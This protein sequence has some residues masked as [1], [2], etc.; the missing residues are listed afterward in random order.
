MANFKL[1]SEIYGDVCR[2]MGDS[3]QSRL[4]EAKAII[5]MVYLQEIMNCDPLYPCLWFLAYLD[6]SVLTKDS[7]TITGITSATPPVVSAAAHGFAN[8][9]IVQIAGVVGMTEV[10]NRI[11]VVADRAAG[12]FELQSLDG[13]DIVGLG[14][15]AWSSGGTI[16]H[17]G[18]TLGTLIEKI[19][20]AAWHGYSDKIEPIGEAELEKTTSWWDP[21][22]SGRPSRYLLKKYLTAAGAEANRLLWFP[23]SDDNYQMRSW[24]EKQVPRLSADGDVPILPFKFHDAIVAGSIARMVKYEGVEIDNAV[25][26]PGLYRAHLEAIKTANRAWW[27]T[28]EKNNERRPYLL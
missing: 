14:Y 21:A 4:E 23:L 15:T 24:Q 9:D 13:T 10:N 5:N 2:G 12:T 1:F 16:Y 18:I 25:I 19:L 22:N 3:Q 6:D 28:F 17:R 26:W 7:K 20:T 8:G 11:F 27:E